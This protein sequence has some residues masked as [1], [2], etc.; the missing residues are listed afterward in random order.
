M[1]D[2]PLFPT[3]YSIVLLVE[4]AGGALS[5]VIVFPL[6]RLFETRFHAHGRVVPTAADGHFWEQGTPNGTGEISS[7]LKA[8]PGAEPGWWQTDYIPGPQRRDPD[9]FHGRLGCEREEEFIH[10]RQLVPAGQ[11]HLLLPKYFCQS[12]TSSDC[13]ANT[14]EAAINFPSIAPAAAIRHLQDGHR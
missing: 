7:I 14:T 3:N 4:S 5:A 13:R 9:C 12:S 10:A 8:H 11:V 2:F 6:R 1:L